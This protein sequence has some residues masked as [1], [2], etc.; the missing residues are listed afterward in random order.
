VR[1]RKLLRAVGLA[2]L[3][4][5]FSWAVLTLTGVR[6]FLERLTTKW[7]L[8]FYQPF[9]FTFLTL[10]AAVYFW[11]QRSE[12]LIKDA[13]IGGL[14]GLVAGELAVLLSSYLQ[15]GVDGFVQGL[16]T[17]GVSYALLLVIVTFFPLCCWLYGALAVGC[18]GIVERYFLSEPEGPFNGDCDGRET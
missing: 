11:W 14:G 6:P 5:T 2:I 4:V 15:Y 1:Y 12:S 3:G 7:D 10:L 8:G 18:S 9:F 16:R 17:S 13:I